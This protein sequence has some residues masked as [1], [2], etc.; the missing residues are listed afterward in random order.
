MLTSTFRTQGFQRLLVVGGGPGS[1]EELKAALCATGVRLDLIDGS[2]AP[3]AARTR[4]LARNADIIVIWAGTILPHSVSAQLANANNA[5]RTI[6]V[7][8][9]GVQALVQGIMEHCYSKEAERCAA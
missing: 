5:P 3:D 4:N 9:R 7:A 1:H 8:R 2:R 6:T